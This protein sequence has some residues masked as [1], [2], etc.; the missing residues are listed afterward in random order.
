[1]FVEHL[2]IGFKK[3]KAE[4]VQEK[5]SGVE[6]LSDERRLELAWPFIS[7]SNLFRKAYNLIL[8]FFLF[9]RTWTCH[10]TEEI[11]KMRNVYFLRC[12]WDLF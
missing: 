1:M 7:S 5:G 12:F 9:N 10:S 3:S 2:L 4:F 11:S 8:Y 6:L